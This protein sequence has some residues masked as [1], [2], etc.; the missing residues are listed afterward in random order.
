[1][2]I[3]NSELALA[4]L[5]TRDSGLGTRKTCEGLPSPEPQGPSSESCM[6]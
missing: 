2:T 5:K 4:G 1:L 3:R 6:R